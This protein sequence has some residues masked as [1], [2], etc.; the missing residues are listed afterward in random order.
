MEENMNQLYNTLGNRLKKS[1]VEA[2]CRETVSLLASYSHCLMSA[3]QK[4]T[5]LSERIAIVTKLLSAVL[6]QTPQERKVNSGDKIL[7]ISSKVLM[8]DGTFVVHRDVECI[9]DRPDGWCTLAKVLFWE[10]ATHGIDVEAYTYHPNLQ[11]RKYIS[12][13][14]INNIV[15]DLRLMDQSYHRAFKKF[16]DNYYKTTSCGAC[17][18]EAQRKCR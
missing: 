12:N 14:E 4:A 16:R 8:D 11:D 17:A 2:W 6:F 10:H 13:E 9:S 5:M 7:N 1:D 3:E 15:N 18:K